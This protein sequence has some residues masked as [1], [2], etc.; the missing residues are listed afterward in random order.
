MT[1]LGDNKIH[2]FGNSNRMY[3]GDRLIYQLL[4]K[5]I[6]DD[7]GGDDVG[8]DNESVSGEGLPNIPFIFNFNAKNYSNGVIPNSEGSIFGEDLIFDST[9][10][11]DVYDDHLVFNS[12]C[13]YGKT[14]NSVDEN[15][16]NR[17]YGQPLTIIAKVQNPYNSELHLLANRLWGYNW[18]FRIYDKAWLHTSQGEMYYCPNVP[19]DS[20]QPN[21]VAIRCLTDGTGY[22]YNYTTGEQGETMNVDY[23]GQSDGF[24][25]F[26]GYAEGDM[27][28]TFTNGE[29]YWIYVSTEQLTD[30]QIQQV[31]IYNE[32]GKFTPPSVDDGGDDGG[33][34][35][36][37]IEGDWTTLTFDFDKSQPFQEVLIDMNNV[38]DDIRAYCFARFSITQNGDYSNAYYSICAVEDSIYDDGN[39]ITITNLQSVGDNVYYYKFSQPIYVADIEENFNVERIKIKIS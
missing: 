2:K 27:G 35:D 6:I 12:S 20:T 31:I 36:I 15:P 24:G 18:M 38:E 23:G 1:Y 3:L 19:L 14:Y 32:D 17:D 13:T 30:E 26:K 34:D 37:V 9:D 5:P 8:D 10:G 4:T 33:D 7:G 29:F 25:I 39:M 22:G 28:E 21:I 11:L 16:L